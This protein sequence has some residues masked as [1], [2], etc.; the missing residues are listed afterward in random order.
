MGAI[1]H[2]KKKKVAS[3]K[4]KIEK[5]IDMCVYAYKIS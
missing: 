4:D 3:S 1:T 2:K 5:P